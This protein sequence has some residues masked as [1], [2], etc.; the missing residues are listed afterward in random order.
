[1]AGNGPWRSGT[2]SLTSVVLPRAILK[3]DQAELKV[4]EEPY[5]PHPA[6]GHH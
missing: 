4:L 3:L 5:Q 2:S 1:M 6:L